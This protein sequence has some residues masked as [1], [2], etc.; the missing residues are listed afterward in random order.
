MFMTLLTIDQS[1]LAW[2]IGIVD[3]NYRVINILDYETWTF[4]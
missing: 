4:C 2:F 3:L 1:S